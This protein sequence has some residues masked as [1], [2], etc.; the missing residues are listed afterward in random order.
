MDST[1]FLREFVSRG[2]APVGGPGSLVIAASH[3]ANTPA[4]VE[5]ARLA[6]AA[7]ASVL[8]ASRDATSQLAK[9]DTPVAGSNPSGTRSPGQTNL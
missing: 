2:P 9:P 1:R 3:S 8:A 7:R 5:A 6:R 4:T